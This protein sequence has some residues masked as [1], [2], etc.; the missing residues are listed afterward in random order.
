MQRQ[1]LPCSLVQTSV[2]WK[3]VGRSSHQY[4]GGQQQLRPKSTHR[5]SSIP[6]TQ[7]R[8]LGGTYHGEILKWSRLLDILQRRSQILQLQIHTSLRL[9]GILHSLRLESLNGLDL[10]ANIV[11][12]GLECGKVLLD[13]IDHGLVLQ[14]G[15]VVREVDL[16]WLLGKD[17]NAAAGVLIALLEGLEGGGGL[18]SETKR[19]GNFCPV[20]LECCTSLWENMY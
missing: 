15:L 10:S 20:E 19:L 11:G 8:Q 17:L 14:D 9:L 16:R 4:L 7:S 12:R 2:P 13:L 6:L 3:R 18:A 5:I 1:N